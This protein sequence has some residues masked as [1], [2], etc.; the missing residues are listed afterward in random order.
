MSGT[1]SCSRALLLLATLVSAVP[2]FAQDADKGRAIYVARCQACHGAEG[3]GDGP[4]ARALPQK[5]RD[6]R[7]ADFWREFD[8]AELAAIITAGRPGTVMRGFP[9]EPAQ[10]KQ[11]L[12]Y[13][14]T[15]QP[16]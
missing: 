7:R 11:L 1:S 5:P 16:R 2:A 15:F 14:R 9:M 13:L 10:M 3:R 8:D 4:A 6:M 12:A